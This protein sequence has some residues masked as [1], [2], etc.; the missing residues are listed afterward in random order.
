[1]VL[2]ITIR[3]YH[4]LL[5]TALL[6][7]KTCGSLHSKALERRAT[8]EILQK[9]ACKSPEQI[10][11]IVDNPRD[12]VRLV[13]AVYPKGDCAYT[14]VLLKKLIENNKSIF[15][16]N[17]YS[18]KILFISSKDFR[19]K[20]YNFD[21][22]YVCTFKEDDKIGSIDPDFG[23]IKPQ[24]NLEKLVKA[25]EKRAKGAKIEKDYHFADLD[26]KIEDIFETL[27]YK[28]D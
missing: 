28:P 5:L 3:R 24:E 6:L 12:A 2:G 21:Y 22:H 25:I 27:N 14:S 20:G 16:N 1:M 26:S 10:L 15:E 8:F 17:K 13:S 9:C 18:P 23:Y 7:G 11:K 19:L 4:I